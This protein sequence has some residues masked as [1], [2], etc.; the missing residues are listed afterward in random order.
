MSVCEDIKREFGGLFE[1]EPVNRHIRIRTPFL[2]PDGDLVD[3]FYREEGEQKIITDLG[4]TMRWLR[5]QT[6]SPKRTN[7]QKALIQDICMT[8]GVEF[9]QGELLVRVSPGQS[10]SEQLSHLSQAIMRASD[11]WLTYRTRT[12]YTFVDE[13]EEFLEEK[14]IRYSKNDKLIGRSQRPYSIDFRTFHPKKSSCMNVLSTGS[15]SVAK[16]KVDS[17]FTAWND[18]SYLRTSDDMQFVSLIDDSFDVWTPEDLNLLGRIS[19][20]AHSSDMNELERILT[21]EAAA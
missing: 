19:T 21:G 16:N 15:K 14:N 3:L 10:L 20:L 12:P 7:K 4:E 17:S 9:F 5:S 13:I 8:L 6:L 2:Y 11:L 18:L 1:C